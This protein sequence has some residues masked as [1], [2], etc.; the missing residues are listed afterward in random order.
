M[1]RSHALAPLAGASQTAA[2]STQRM[3]GER[4]YDDIH[5]RPHR[6]ARERIMQGGGIGRRP[7]AAVRETPRH[8]P[9]GANHTSPRQRAAALELGCLQ[10]TPT[11]SVK[12]R[13]QADF[14]FDEKLHPSQDYLSATNGSM[15]L[16]GT[17]TP[18]LQVASEVA[19]WPRERTPHGHR[20]L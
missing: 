11:V 15:P 1:I 8:T 2:D 17:R 19:A 5:V 12:R 3:R 10:F 18:T 9:D 6:K 14:Y 13:R 7:N 4:G 16:P 20:E